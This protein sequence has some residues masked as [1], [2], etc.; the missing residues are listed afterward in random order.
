MNAARYFMRREDYQPRRTPPESPFRN[1]EVKC[2]KCG[3]FKLTIT[4]QFD[5]QSGEQ[6][7]VFVC[8]KCKQQEKI[9]I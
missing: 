6:I 4:A 7:A 9:R 1:F 5:E 8:I 2:L 3:S